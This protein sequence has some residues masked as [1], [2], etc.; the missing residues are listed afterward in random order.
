MTDERIERV[1]AGLEFSQRG[2]TMTTEPQPS[3][4]Q[5]LDDLDSL[6]QETERL[7]T[8][9]QEI[10]R[11]EDEDK[12]LS[13]LSNAY[14]IART[15]LTEGEEEEEELDEAECCHGHGDCEIH[16]EKKPDIVDYGFLDELSANSRS[17][18]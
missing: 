3:W 8:A 4:S 11:T 12:S 7:R 2:G 5:L 1:R 14:F 13:P 9:L 15:A 17:P 18:I 6:Q 16:S 10:V